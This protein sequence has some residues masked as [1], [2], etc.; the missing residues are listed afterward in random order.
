MGRNGIDSVT[1]HVG[2]IHGVLR[3]RFRCDSKRARQPADGYRGGRQLPNS[4]RLWRSARIPAELRAR[5]CPGLFRQKPSRSTC[6]ARER[7]GFAYIAVS[8][9][10]LVRLR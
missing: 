7:H 5:I 9:L 8:Q 6:A 10:L 3:D 1:H 2:T 4:G